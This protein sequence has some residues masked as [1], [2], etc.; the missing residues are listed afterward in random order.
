MSEAVRHTIPARTTGAYLV[1]AAAGQ[2]PSPLLVG[3]HGYSGTA[4][5]CL[6]ELDRI[7]GSSAYCAVAVQALHRFYDSRHREVV[8]SW[9]TSLDR[10][11]AIADNVEYVA[12]VR[13]ALEDSVPGDGR[14][15]YLGFSQ[16]TSMA[17]RAAARG[18]RPASGIV[19][20][21]GDL[22][23]DVGD[24]TAVHLPPVLIGRGL[25]DEWYTEEKLGKDLER[26]K[27]RGAEVEVV[28]FDGGHAWTDEFRSAVGS[29]LLRR[30]PL[31]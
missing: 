7:P 25:R 31:L 22:P 1:R 26:L 16:G 18:T 5:G 10:D 28:R 21:G 20:L 27:A 12:S 4:E 17:Y 29:F 14:I 11:L 9:M 24:D 2:G 23:P 3:F 13:R 8:G 30:I 15:V 6:S 19:A